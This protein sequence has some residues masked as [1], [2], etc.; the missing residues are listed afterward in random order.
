MVCFTKYNTTK[1]KLRT[2]YSDL[3]KSNPVCRSDPQSVFDNTISK[4]NAFTHSVLSFKIW[5]LK[6][7]FRSKM[8]PRNLV[9]SKTGISEPSKYKV[10][11]RCNLL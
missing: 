9:H 1:V 8:R 3:S 4:F 6:F 5:D 11:F 10:E 2:D 7:N